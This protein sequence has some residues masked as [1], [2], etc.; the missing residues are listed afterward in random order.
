MRHRFSVIVIALAVIFVLSAGIAHAQG[1]IQGKFKPV[2]EKAASDQ[3]FDPHDFT[4]IWEMTVRD[5]T[6]GTKPPPL[7]PAGKAAMA[8][9]IAGGGASIGNQPWYTCNPMGFPRLL[10]DDEP[11]E[12]IINKD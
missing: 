6:L 10:N 5:H 2:F 3:Q 12:W 1:A 4:G 9:R 11:M 7:T 8:G